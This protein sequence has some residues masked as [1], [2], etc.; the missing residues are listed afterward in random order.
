MKRF[1][2]RVSKRFE[3]FRSASKRVE[4]CRSALKHRSALKR[5]EAL[6]NSLKCFEA[7]E[8]AK[9]ENCCEPLRLVEYSLQSMC[10]A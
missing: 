4:A 9:L 8:L 10:F 2:D 6:R 3:A 1:G 5:S 7:W